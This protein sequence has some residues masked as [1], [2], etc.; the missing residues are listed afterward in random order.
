MSNLYELNCINLHM[1]LVIC[2]KFPSDGSVHYKH[3]DAVPSI[4]IQDET[5]LSPHDGE[6]IHWQ[7]DASPMPKIRSLMKNIYE[8]IHTNYKRHEVFPNLFV[9]VQICDCTSTK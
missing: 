9:Q 1:D 5:T 7:N 2:W 3:C 8:T 6:L 4:F